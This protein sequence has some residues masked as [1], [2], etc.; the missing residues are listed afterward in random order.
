MKMFSKSFLFGV[1]AFFLG[2][3]TFT[4][5]K[6]FEVVAEFPSDT[7]PGNIAISKEGRI[8]LSVHSFYPSEFRLV[9]LL[10]NGKTAPYPSPDW[11]RTP[12]GENAPGL[13]NVLGLNTDGHGTLWVLDNAG[14][15]HVGRLVAFDL[16]KNQVKRVIYLPEPITRED[17]FLN[18]LA[19]DSG[20]NA[21]YISDTG[22]ASSAAIIV[23]DLNTGIARRILEG[24]ESTISEGFDMVIDSKVV[25]LGGQPAHIGI[26]PITIDEQSEW[27][28]F[29]SMT[30][31]AIYR[32]QTK[33]L[34]DPN[35]PKA[36]LA[37]S[38]QTY[39]VKPISDGSTIDN[40][41][42]VYITAIADAAIGVVKPDGTYTE[43]FTD[44]TLAWPD[45]LATGPDGF[46]YATINEL[47]RSPVLNGGENDAQ[48]LFKVIRFKPLAEVSV[49]R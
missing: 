11:A 22:A 38:V 29:G 12:E 4:S 10:D 37:N 18:D 46:I 47:H 42:N 3:A 34:L 17:S 5:A 30:G 36:A 1:L 43:L 28:Y 45:G 24:T 31:K 20:N 35:L 32:V 25:T 26:N 23:V 6:G 41:G 33:S 40:E 8:F 19:V 44:E 13:Q 2:T 15:S 21:I 14:D 16:A 27:V 49:G 39:G 48:G 7:P 9:E